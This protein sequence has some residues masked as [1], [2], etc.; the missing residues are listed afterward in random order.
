MNF[1]E[2]INELKDIETKLYSI[3]QWI[4]VNRISKEAYLKLWEA[5]ELTSDV[6]VEL[7]NEAKKRNISINIPI[8]SET[9]FVCVFCGQ[10]FQSYRITRKHVIE[11]HQEFLYPSLYVLIE[12]KDVESEQK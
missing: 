3:I 9:R 4:S 1:E 7:K 8:R 6:V 10:I 5:R 2:A 11:E 12:E